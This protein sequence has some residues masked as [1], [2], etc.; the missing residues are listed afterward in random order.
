MTAMPR[1]RRQALLLLASVGIVGCP[2]HPDGRTGENIGELGFAEFH[3]CSP[4]DS[5][6]CSSS[7]SPRYFAR[8]SSFGMQF[9][10]DAG[11]PS[12]V[13]GQRVVPVSQRFVA[14]SGA[15][16][17]ALEA[18]T[19]AM[20]AL[21]TDN[22]VIDL[23]RIRIEPIERIGVTQSVCEDRCSPPPVMQR[24]SFSPQST[25]SVVATPW[26]GETKLSGSLP[27]TWTSLDPDVVTISS[28]RQERATLVLTEGLGRIQVSAGGRTEEVLIVASLGPRRHPQAP[29]PDTDSGTMT[30]GTGAD[31]DDTGTGTGASSTGGT[32][33]AGETGDGSLTEASTAGDPTDET[34]GTGGDTRPTST[35][36][37]TGP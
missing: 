5:F 29:I 35:G 13:R 26:A 24:L 3:V 7:A 10:I 23:L 8:S 6:D 16:F 15:G 31:T 32:D 14:T 4:H 18:G 33:T 21:S 1:L 9:T 11:V 2:D 25:V 20:L 19:V 36:S 30:A 12:E 17:S 34:A 28:Q 27:Y 37:E 22:D